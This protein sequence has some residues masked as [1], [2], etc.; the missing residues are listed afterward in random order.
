[1]YLRNLLLQEYSRGTSQSQLVAKYHV[2]WRKLRKI[3]NSGRV[4]IRD[5]S[6]QAF[7]EK[8][9]RP[10]LERRG[11]SQWKLYVIFAMLGDNL[12]PSSQAIRGTHIIGIAAGGDRDF[13]ENWIY[14][15]EQEYR[16]RPA[17]VIR[18]VNN[19]QTEI[20]SLDIWRDLH[21]YATFGRKC[22]RLSDEMLRHLLSNN[23]PSRLVGYGLR[24]FFDAEGS[25]KYQRDRAARQITAYSINY[26]G[27]G[28][29]SRVLQK[30]AIKHSLYKNSIAIFGR[31]N[32]E[33]F[34]KLIG[35]SIRRK[36]EALNNMISSFQRR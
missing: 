11:I 33:S 1:M 28:Q 19:I 31:P 34:Q 36:N 4:A 22:W 24:G 26:A 17:L 3:L 8:Y 21:R 14:N 23:V 16:V 30:L 2:E 6:Q 29:V 25:V 32:L 18:G 12:R 5:K 9:G 35:F 10:P 20:S 15:F 27:L 7:I 13:A